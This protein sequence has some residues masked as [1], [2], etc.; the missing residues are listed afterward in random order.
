MGRQS[1][2]SNTGSKDRLHRAKTIDLCQN[3]LTKEPKLE[4]AKHIPEWEEYDSE[5]AKF[6]RELAAKGVIHSGLA[7][8]DANVLADVGVIK[9]ATE[10]S[11]TEE[12]TESGAH[13]KD[14]L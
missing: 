14:E 4:R 8:A 12:P 6:T 9:S 11:A 5:I 1:L 3:P 10:S 13:T 7:A 2:T